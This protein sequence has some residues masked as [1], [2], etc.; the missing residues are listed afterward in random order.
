MK[1]KNHKTHNTDYMVK[2]FVLVLMCE[3]VH[4]FTLDHSVC[5]KVLGQ[6]HMVGLLGVIMARKAMWSRA[7]CYRYRTHGVVMWLGSVI[8][9]STSG[10]RQCSHISYQK[11][12]SQEQGP[13]SFFPILQEPGVI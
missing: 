9:Y 4:S 13:P 12:L 1:L 10:V 2:V 5:N 3:N 6:G 8:E 7:M 11:N